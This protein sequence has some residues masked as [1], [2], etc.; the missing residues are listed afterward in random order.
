MSLL[1]R[2]RRGPELRLGSA[3]AM[4]RAGDGSGRGKYVSYSGSAV[5]VELIEYSHRLDGVR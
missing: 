2:D 4:D 5:E 1:R 3:P